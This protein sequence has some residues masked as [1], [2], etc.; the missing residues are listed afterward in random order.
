MHALLR[1]IGDI[2]EHQYHLNEICRLRRGGKSLLKI[3]D[4]FVFVV[5]ISLSFWIETVSTP[6][7]VLGFLIFAVGSRIGSRPWYFWQDILD[8]IVSKS[9]G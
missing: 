2:F 4:V 6:M 9:Y 3:I 7:Y 5:D 8:C 1:S